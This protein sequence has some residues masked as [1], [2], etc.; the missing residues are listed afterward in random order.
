M[1]THLANSAGIKPSISVARRLLVVWRN[2]ESRRFVV[3]AQL[4]QL[5]SGSFLFAYAERASSEP[6]FFPID[7]YPDLKATYFSNSL[8]V[9]FSNRVMS[10]DRASY[11]EY[12]Q[13]VGLAS[14]RPD[15]VPMELLARTGGGRA[16]DTFHVVESPLDEAHHFESRFFVSGISHVPGGSALVSRLRDGAR[17][18]LR[19]EPTNE[20][21]PRAVLLDVEDNRPIGWVPDWLCEPVSV[22]IEEGYALQAVV[23]RVNP[24]APARQ[25]VLA[26]IDANR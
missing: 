14:F 9:F 17:L 15:D 13:R 20:V 4:D 26:R 10:S 19:P 3:V 24:D 8:P 16:T 21:N 6:G 2:P 12:L 25:Q 1:H 5:V 22:L 23:E 7:E 11:Q 18:S